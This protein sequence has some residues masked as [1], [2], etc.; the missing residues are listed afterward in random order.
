MCI[1]L[2]INTQDTPTTDS[3]S[4]RIDLVC[5]RTKNLVACCSVSCSYRARIALE[6]YSNRARIAIVLG[7][8]AIRARFKYCGVH[9]EVHGT[10]PINQSNLKHAEFIEQ[11]SDDTTF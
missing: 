4:A 10:R 6:S 7:P 9:G 1:E 11:D 5:E 8:F 3:R 2:S